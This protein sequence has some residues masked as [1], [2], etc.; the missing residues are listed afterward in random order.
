MRSSRVWRIMWHPRDLLSPLDLH[1]HD[2]S[3]M[4][5]GD[6]SLSDAVK[7]TMYET[8]RSAVLLA[9]ESLDLGK[10]LRAAWTG[11]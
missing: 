3:Y 9:E 11:T 6:E 2:V 8:V 7:A 5:A 10:D 4:R 1:W